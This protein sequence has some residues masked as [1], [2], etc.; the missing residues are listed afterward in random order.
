MR[1]Q[2]FLGSDGVGLVSRIVREG[3]RRFPAL[4]GHDPDD[5]V[6]EFFVDRIQAMTAMLLAQATSDDAFGRLVRRSVQNWMIDQ[7]RK[8]GTGPLRRAIEKVLDES[9]QFERVPTGIAGAGRWRLTHTD[10]EPWGGDTGQLIAVAWA[11][12]NVR[13]PKWSSSSRRPPVADRASL[14]AI[15]HAILQQAGGSLETAQLVHVF[16]QRFAASLDPIVV[17]LDERLDED[18]DEDA[19]GTDLPSETA[20]PE[21]AVIAESVALDVAGAAAEIVGRLS[22]VERA[23]IPV[24]NDS[25][26]VRERLSLGRSQSALFT[27]TLKAKI[28]ALAGT[29]EDRDDI[30]REVIALCGGPAAS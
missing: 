12:P 16:C 28:R 15:A 11:V 29:G 26:A 5:V 19:A 14:V 8:T 1:E 18:P 20:S 2:G 10:G 27:S 22:A 6:Q 9:P 30:V 4:E 24:L 3:L 23:I 7:A 21:E 13:V 25:A 17:S